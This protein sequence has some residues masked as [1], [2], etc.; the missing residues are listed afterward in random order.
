MKSKFNT[1]EVASVE[2]DGLEIERSSECSYVFDSL[3]KCLKISSKVLI[4]GNSSGYSEFSIPIERLVTPYFGEVPY[5]I[6]IDNDD[7]NCS[8]STNISESDDSY[9]I[10]NINAD[11]FLKCR[12]KTERK[13]L[14]QF[15]YEIP[16]FQS[17]AVKE[18]EWM[19]GFFPDVVN[20][21]E[22]TLSN[23]LYKWNEGYKSIT[24]PS[25]EDLITYRARELLLKYEGDSEHKVFDPRRNEFQYKVKLAPGD[26]IE[27]SNISGKINHPKFGS[28]NYLGFITDDYLSFKNAGKKF[29]M[30]KGVK[31]YGFF[32]THN[33]LVYDFEYAYSVV[34]DTPGVLKCSINT[35]S[36]NVFWFK[37]PKGQVEVTFKAMQLNKIIERIPLRLANS[38]V[39]IQNKINQMNNENKATFE[40]WVS[41]AISSH[42][43]SIKAMV[44]VDKVFT[45]R[46]EISA[47]IKKYIM[48]QKPS[49][50]TK[51]GSKGKYLELNLFYQGIY[52]SKNSNTFY[53]SEIRLGKVL[54]TTKVTSSSVKQYDKELIISEDRLESAKKVFQEQDNKTLKNISYKKLTAKLIE[55]KKDLNSGNKVEFNTLVLNRYMTQ[56][57]GKV[58]KY[59]NNSNQQKQKI[60]LNRVRAIY[61]IPLGGSVGSFRET[62]PELFTKVYKYLPK[63][64]VI[65]TF[66]DFDEA[67]EQCFYLSAENFA[68]KNYQDAIFTESI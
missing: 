25:I 61:D 20:N 56:V 52:E 37:R 1:R 7:M 23:I 53:T 19:N 41:R 29:L 43:R 14:L 65:H 6:S 68:N 63:E 10:K 4:Y 50:Y 67:S 49:F 16:I 51:P 3:E 47:K 39:R 15:S 31:P 35:R 2:I 55:V 27:V 26:L 13:T 33:G 24:K 17:F 21:A 9:M 42:E 58:E 36:Y 64:K 45:Y 48:L 60:T 18:A 8:H 22:L 34:F 62:S 59:L 11:T 5:I 57:C 40:K 30:P 32:C 46:K 12:N 54:T 66:L 28:S 44:E 38:K